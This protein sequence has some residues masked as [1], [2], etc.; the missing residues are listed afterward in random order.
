MKTLQRVAAHNNTLPENALRR[1]LVHSG[2]SGRMHKLFRK[3]LAGAISTWRPSITAWK[4]KQSQVHLSALQG[5]AV[6]LYIKRWGTGEDISVVVLGGSISAGGEVRNFDT[7]AYFPQTTVR[8]P[9]P[10]TAAALHTPW[11]SHLS[12]VATS[13]TKAEYSV[14]WPSEGGH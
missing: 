7:E 6:L 11:H 12:V 3:V 2:P 9:F 14:S 10:C 5:E 4:G 13:P 8:P 1:S